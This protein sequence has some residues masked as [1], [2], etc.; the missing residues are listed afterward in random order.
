MMPTII[1]AKDQ[2]KDGEE[3][4]FKLVQV[5]IKLKEIRDH[6]SAKSPIRLTTLVKANDV[7]VFAI[8]DSVYRVISSAAGSRYDRLNVPLQTDDQ[9]DHIF[10]DHTGCHCIISLCKGTP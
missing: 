4:P 3:S 7:T 6:D 2:M 5:D 8:S 1:R 10:L 9:I